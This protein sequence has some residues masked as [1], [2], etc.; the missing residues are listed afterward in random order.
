MKIRKNKVDRIIRGGGYRSD[1]RYRRI[2]FRDWAGPGFD[3]WDYGFRI[4]VRRK[5]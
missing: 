4:V 1:S 2:I 3:H 5:P